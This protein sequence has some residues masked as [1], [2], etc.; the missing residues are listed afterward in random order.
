VEEKDRIAI[1]W[2]HDRTVEKLDRI[3]ALQI[4][5]LDHL[6]RTIHEKLDRIEKLLEEQRAHNT[7]VA[8]R[9]EEMKE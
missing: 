7:W 6:S 8:D 9:L 2:L 4:D 3:E 1:R 5:T